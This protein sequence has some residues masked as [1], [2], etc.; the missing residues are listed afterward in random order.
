MNDL[1]IYNQGGLD[2]FQYGIELVKPS[3]VRLGIG[4]FVSE[5]NIWESM[6]AKA[7]QFKMGLVDAAGLVAKFGV[8]TG[9]VVSV[10]L[11]LHDNDAGKIVQDF[12]ILDIGQGD[13]TEN[14]LGRTF[15]ISGLHISAHLNQLKPVTKSYKGSFD[16]IVQGIC[17]DYLNIADL[18]VESAG[19]QRTLVPQGGKPFDVI[20]WCC[21]QAQNAAGDAD[22]LYMFW[23]TSD[24]HV[25]RTLRTQLAQAIVHS[26][27]VAVDKNINSD[28]SD[29]F[30]ILGFQQLK[31]GHQATRTAGGLYENELLQFNHFNRNITS[32]KKNYVDQQQSVQVLRKQPVADLQQVSN[33]W[34]SDSSV[35]TPGLS[36]M[37]KI[38]SDDATVGQQNSYEQK[39]NAATM[40]TQLFNQICFSIEVYG[41]PSIKAG[42]VID[43]DAPELSSADNR[44]KDWVLHGKFLV[45]D[46]RHR[47]WRAEHYRTYLTVYAD[48][49]DT[50]IMNG[51]N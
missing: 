9:D 41:N 35:Q 33:N 36:A 42:D 34:I 1:I 11:A 4:S 10:S 14:S 19:G 49:Y 16:Q 8:Q 6:F 12:V 39:F 45:A 3:G 46:V 37:V 51:G 20:G 48:G 13:R 24:G 50:N 22:S 44:G 7:L 25:F 27:T 15:V 26:Y 21:K 38:R 31:L 17:K 29:V 28:S 5:F 32:S 43:V 47:V 30:R 23:Q 40:Q 2:T 18:Q